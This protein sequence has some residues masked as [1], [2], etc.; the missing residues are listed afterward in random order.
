MIDKKDIIDTI[1]L[2]KITYPSSL[3]DIGET[4]LKMMIEVWYNDFKDTTKEDFNKAI[5]EIR[6]T[7]KYFPS[8]ADIKEKLAKTKTSNLPDAEDEWQDVIRAVRQYGSW[9]E[10][11]A[12]ES[13]KPYTRKITEYIGFNRICMATPE[14]QKW[15]KKEFVE[16]YNSLVNKSATNLQI[17]I[18]ERNLLN[19]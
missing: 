15:N 3:K 14:E 6:Y 2:L 7:N 13:L 5:Q 9:S 1:T 17:G 18:N 11:E 16:E 12:L 19:E 8:I 10:K 4:E